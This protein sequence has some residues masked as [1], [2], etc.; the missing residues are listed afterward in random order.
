MIQE[1]NAAHVEPETDSARHMVHMLMQFALAVRYR[2]NVVILSLVITFLLCGL[3]YAT[4]TRYYVSTAGLV[5]QISADAWSP[6]MATQDNWQQSMLP[7][8]QG[9]IT[10]SEVIKGAIDRIP[11]EHAVDFIH[12]P[13]DERVKVIQSQ[14]SVANLRK[15]NIV[16]V[17]FRSKDPN[18]A[19]TVVNAIV[20]SYQD[21]T[22][23][24]YKRNATRSLE[25]LNRQ[26]EEVA[27]KLEKKNT[28]LDRARQQVRNLGISSKS[29]VLHPAQQAVITLNEQY[30]QSQLRRM[31]LE[32]SLESIQE[33]MARGEDLQQK[34]L[35][36]ADTV[37]H[38]VLLGRL[39][40]NSHDAGL[41]NELIQNHV[42]DQAELARMRAYRGPAHPAV[43]DLETKIR[44]TEGSLLGAQ[45]RLKRRLAQLQD[46]Q[47]GPM[48]IE[49]IQQK[50]GT[51]R[52]YEQSLK[53]KLDRA[54]AKAVELGQQ[55]F[56]LEELERERDLCYDELKVVMKHLND[57]DLANE[58]QDVRVHRVDEPKVDAHPVSPNLA[59]TILIALAFGLGVGLSLVYVSD[60]LDDRF[61]SMEEMQTLLGVPVLAMVRELKIGEETG[62]HTLQTYLAPNASESEAFRTLRTALSLAEH[63]THQ[64]VVSSP[65]PGDGKTTVLAN[66]AVAVAQSGKRTLLIDADLR[67]PGLTAMLGMRG[68][69]GLSSVIRGEDDIV[70]MAEA[71]VRPSGLEGLDVL[72]SGPRPTN[73][74]ELLGQQRFSELLAWAESIYDQIFI[75]SPPTLATSDSAVIG[76]LT[77]AVVLVVQPAKN[78]RR[79][80][81]RCVEN[82]AVLKIPLLGIVVNRVGSGKEGGYYG[83]GYGG[84]YGYEYAYRYDADSEDG[85]DREDGKDAPEF[86]VA[87]VAPLNVSGVGEDDDPGGDAASRAGG[88]VPR[89]VA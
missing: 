18:A 47:L 13:E 37:G 1:S 43:L 16:E 89:R 17:G 31:E 38:E 34:V 8:Y 48:L 55:L 58:G 67:R 85:E 71:H 75:D 23:T 14:L 40:L 66:L 19:K 72:P 52:E 41:Q 26:K 2:R 54:E 39:S 30:V 88:I 12:Y 24:T 70:R 77:N 32:D 3:Y 27:A 50:L 42:E 36:L 78:R 20:D 84:Y 44:E 10:R 76:R 57:V 80:V 61:R 46:R 74:A 45:D 22:N 33:A 65:E 5:L 64:I 53:D 82:L 83:Y 9:L 49:L 21:F 73:P 79:M 56:W 63:D 87:G 35:A 25:A 6:G 69:D 11:R 86:D 29:E 51:A 28:E 62:I 15:T 4:A 60:I 7:T 59:R 81:M 68:I